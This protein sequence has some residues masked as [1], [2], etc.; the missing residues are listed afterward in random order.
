MHEPSYDWRAA[1]RARLERAHLAPDDQADMVEEIGQHLE[2]QFAELA[3]TIGAA[4]AREQLLAQLRNDEL[5][6]AIARKRRLAKPS[7]ARVWSSSSLLR[8][9]RQSMRSLRRS[10]ATVAA[11]SAA[12][13]L[14]IGLTATMFSIIYGLLIKGLPFDDPSRIAVVKLID[15]RQP[16][17][18]APVS[19]GDFAH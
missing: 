17:V 1:V 19:L 7:R 5:E 15:P 11:G 3:P 2:Q 6:G 16:G 14:G 9:V 12:L 4:K 13:A 18:D 10:P 8:D